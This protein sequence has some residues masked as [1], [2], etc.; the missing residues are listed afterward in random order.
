[1]HSVYTV[2]AMRVEICS[3]HVMWCNK[4]IRTSDWTNQSVQSARRFDIYVYVLVLNA[5]RW[6]KPRMFVTLRRSRTGCRFDWFNQLQYGTVHAEIECE[7]WNVNGMVDFLLYVYNTVSSSRIMAVSS[8]VGC[9]FS[10]VPLPFLIVQ[11]I[12]HSAPKHALSGFANH[13]HW[14]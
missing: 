11:L 12:L 8:F 14:E 7:V 5:G 9:W 4:G 3:C 13:F 1:M 6:P 10:S 2:R